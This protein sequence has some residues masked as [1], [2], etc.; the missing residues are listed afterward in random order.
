[1]NRLSLFAA[2][3]SVLALLLSA[4][5]KQTFEVKGV[6]TG[7]T[8]QVLYF[9]NVGLSKVT[10]L[11]SAKLTPSGKFDF[12]QTRP[13][14]PDFYRFRMN[15]QLI[16]FAIDSTET[17]RF[18]ADAGTFATSYTVEGSESAKNMKTITL[19]QLD[20][21]QAIGKLRAEL[22]GHMLPD[23]TYQNQVTKVADAYKAI[24]RSYIYKAPMSMAAY[25]ALFQQVDGSLIFD[26]Y[27]PEDSKAFG[28]VATSFDYYYPGYARSVQLHNL[29]LQ[30][31]KV[32]RRQRD[33]A[34]EE[35]MKPKEVGYVDISL[36]DLKGNVVSLSSILPGK[37]VLV[38]FT[39][40]QTDWSPSLNMTLAGL[41]EKYQPKGLAIYQVSLDSDRHFWM[42]VADRLPWTCVLDPESV[43]SQVAALYNVRQLPAIFLIDKKGNLVKR[44]ESM[45][46]LEDDIRHLL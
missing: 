8:G 12:K 18:T 14:F 28:A 41:Y 27:N 31:I 1:M 15:N 7:A 44:V 23:T 24:A 26:L 38:S 34:K 42:N 11:D 45:Q 40:Y 4:C 22:K 13:A 2:L 5:G 17:L 16:N 36:P 29:A 46:K 39:A 6:V 9:E 32:I 20:A 21:S 3:G 37:V 35:K 19:A 25:Y 30:S 10:V 43:Y 33:L